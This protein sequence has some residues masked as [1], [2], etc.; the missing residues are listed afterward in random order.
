MIVALNKWSIIPVF[1]FHLCQF[2]FHWFQCRIGT[3]PFLQGEPLRSEEVLWEVCCG[4]YLRPDRHYVKIRVL[5]CNGRGEMYSAS[6]LLV[7]LGAFSWMQSQ[8]RAMKWGLNALIRFLGCASLPTAALHLNPGLARCDGEPYGFGEVG[9]P[10]WQWGIGPFHTQVTDTKGTWV[11][12]APNQCWDPR[13]NHTGVVPSFSLAPVKNS[14]FR[15]G[16]LKCSWLSH[17][18]D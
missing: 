6:T 2:I 12:S 7:S 3:N 10:Q 5:F 14:Q 1:F 16:Y 8:N 4:L 13:S 17:L 18:L 9:P 15:C 11:I